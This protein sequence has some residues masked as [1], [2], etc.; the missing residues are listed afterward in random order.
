MPNDSVAL[1][2]ED[3]DSLDDFLFYTFKNICGHDQAQWN[4]LGPTIA[5]NPK[6]REQ[7]REFIE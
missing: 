1:G 5:K 6:Y 3:F 2:L 7:M 4:V